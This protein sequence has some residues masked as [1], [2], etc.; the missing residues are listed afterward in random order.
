MRD[1]FPHPYT[2]ADADKWIAHLQK[3]G[4]D[5][6]HFA[7]AVEGNAIGCA[8]FQ[9]QKDM[10]RHTAEIG[11]WLGQ[12]YWGRGI[13]TEAV[14]ALTEYGFSHHDRLTRIYGRV[15]EWNV[16]S[17]RVLEKCGYQREGWLRQS[18]MK[19]GKIVDEA[20]YA[21]LRDEHGARQ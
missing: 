13:A 21:K 17:M 12:D 1:S 19:D 10:E 5:A 4:A 8:G 3:Q 20:L 15:F 11:Y 2:L 7:I 6:T 16:A 18:A 9:L 14:R